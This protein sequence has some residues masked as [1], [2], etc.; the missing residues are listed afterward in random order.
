[1]VD[2]DGVELVEEL[3]RLLQ[4]GLEPYV[5]ATVMLEGAEVSAGIVEIVSG[6]ISSS[7]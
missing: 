6:P 3:L 2:S 4:I 1:M 7:T 5:D